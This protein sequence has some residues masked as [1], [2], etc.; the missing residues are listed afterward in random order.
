MYK[1]AQ[2]YIKGIVKRILTGIKAKHKKTL[3][4]NRRPARFYIEF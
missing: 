2:V 3:Q 4:L 1:K